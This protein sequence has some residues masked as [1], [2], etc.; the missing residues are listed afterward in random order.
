MVLVTGNWR[1]WAIGM[2]ASIAIFLV[3]FFA[4]IK[5]STDNA[6]QAIKTGLQQSQQVINQ[7]K[8]QLS[9]SGVTGA[10]ANQAGQQLT[11]ASKLTACV[12]AAGTDTSKLSNCQ[13]QYG[14]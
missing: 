12:A 6:N 11:K 4:V 14:G 13:A 2:V 8:K 3:V 7:A 9:T 1:L 5:P 10:A